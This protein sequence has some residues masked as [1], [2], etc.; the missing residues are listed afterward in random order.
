[1][2]HGSS[3]IIQT[4]E[5]FGGEVASGA[6]GAS[7][8]RGRLAFRSARCAT[9][10]TQVPPTPTGAPPLAGQS[11]RTRKPSAWAAGAEEDLPAQE[12]A[13]QIVTFIPLTGRVGGCRLRKREDV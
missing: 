10:D 5:L 2:K 6:R 4:G 13:C 3:T 7:G 11:G 9:W 8:R 12:Y 1:M